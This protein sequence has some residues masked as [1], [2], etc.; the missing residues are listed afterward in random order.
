M[1]SWQK[2]Q[3]DTVSSGIERRSRWFQF[4]SLFNLEIVFM[5]GKENHGGD[6]LSRL[7]YPAHLSAPDTTI[8]GS[9]ADAEANAADDR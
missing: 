8:H 4:L 6:I 3:L 9:T 7:A 2:E 1:T 5:A